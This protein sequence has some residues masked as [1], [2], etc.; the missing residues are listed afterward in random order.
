LTIVWVTLAAIAAVEGGQETVE[1]W[2]AVV[3]TLWYPP[4][5][6]LPS[7]GTRPAVR[8]GRTG[9]RRKDAY[10]AAVETDLRR[11]RVDP[12]EGQQLGTSGRGTSLYL[13]VALFRRCRDKRYQRRQAR[14]ESDCAHCAGGVR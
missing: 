10:E 13:A 11:R 2:R 9:W 6:H 7:V 1:A 14:E 12:A 5:G 3:G 8:R 4:W